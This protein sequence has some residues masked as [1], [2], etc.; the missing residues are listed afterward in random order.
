MKIY[1]LRHTLKIIKIIFIPYFK[2]L[3][4]PFPVWVHLYVTRRCNLNCPYCFDK[5]DNRNELTEQEWKKAIDKLYSLGTRLIAF[6]G[7]EPTIRKDFVN[8]VG[9]IDKFKE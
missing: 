8:L 7:G 6:M 3:L 1:N 9:K 2:S 5:D 4:K